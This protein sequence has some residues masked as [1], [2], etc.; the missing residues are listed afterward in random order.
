M[1]YSDQGHEMTIFLAN[2]FPVRLRVIRDLMESRRAAD[3]TV[4]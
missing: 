2:I 3:A 4:A 1:T